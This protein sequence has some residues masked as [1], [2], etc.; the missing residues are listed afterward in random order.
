[1]PEIALQ[2]NATCWVCARKLRAGMLAY[3]YPKAD[4][5][6]RVACLECA[7][8]RQKEIKEFLDSGKLPD[9]GPGTGFA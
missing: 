7:Y 4:Y 6:R 3:Y 5:G 9:R 1:M 8:K 2:Y